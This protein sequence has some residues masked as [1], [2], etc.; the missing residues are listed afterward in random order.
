MASA[1]L[2]EDY[3]VQLKGRI[4]AAYSAGGYTLGW[5]LLSSPAAVMDGA[6]IA[7][8]GLNPGG[9]RLRSDHSELAMREGSAYVDEVWDNA[10][11]AGE[12]PLQRQVRALFDRLSVAPENVLAGNL[13]PFRSPS[14]SSLPN[15]RTA[16]AFGEEIWTELFERARPKLVIGMGLELLSPLSRTLGAFDPVRHSVAWGNVTAAKATFPTGKLVVLPHLSRFG[17]VT[18]PQSRPALDLL[19]RDRPA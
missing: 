4:D 8:V 17:I 2:L 12:N 14:W 1:L 6:E 7:F 10:R 13:V 5:R 19:F 16:L 15:S 3:C 18:R 9:A 11:T